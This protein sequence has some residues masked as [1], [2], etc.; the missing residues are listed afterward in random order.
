MVVIT[1][2]DTNNSQLIDK[3]ERQHF[4]PVASQMVW[5]VL[6]EKVRKICAVFSGDAIFLVFL[7]CTANF[8][9]LCSSSL[10]KLPL[11][12]FVL[13]LST[14]GVVPNANKTTNHEEEDSTG[15]LRDGKEN[16]Y[17]P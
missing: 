2:I 11:G 5:D 13:M 17:I 10:S 7:V 9:I 16:K 3:C 8:D 6:F 15:Y 4:K 12:Q 1:C 14:L